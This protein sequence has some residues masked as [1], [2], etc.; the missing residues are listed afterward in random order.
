M[1]ACGKTVGNAGAGGGVLSIVCVEVCLSV[2]LCVVTVSNAGAGSG[3]H[4]F[5]CVDVYVCGKAVICAW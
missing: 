2:C 1:C 5:I 4:S 3:V